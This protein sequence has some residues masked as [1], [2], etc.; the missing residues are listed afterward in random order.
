MFRV[1]RLG[2]KEVVYMSL[3]ILIL[4]MF[5]PLP[6]FWGS[7]GCYYMSIPYTWQVKVLVTQLCPTLSVHG[8]LQ[9]GILE[10]VAI[11]FSG[12]PSQPRDQTQ[13]SHIAGS[14]LTIWATREACTLYMENQDKFHFWSHSRVIEMCWVRR[15]PNRDI[16]SRP[17]SL[18]RFWQWLLDSRI[19]GNFLFILQWGSTEQGF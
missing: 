6:T 4:K 1:R 14:F 16:K 2:S 7:G 17:F 5:D 9:A 13:V 19:V 3:Y 10:W 18:F 15:A 12:G 11:P 8:I